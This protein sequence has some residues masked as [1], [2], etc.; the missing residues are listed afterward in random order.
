MAKKSATQIRKE[1]KTPI[2][3]KVLA[4]IRKEFDEDAARIKDDEIM[5]PYLDTEGNEIYFTV[6]IAIPLGEGHGKIPFDGYSEAEN[7][8]MESERK[9]EERKEREKKKAE[10]IAR[11]EARRKAE[12]EMREKRRKEKEGE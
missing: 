1:T 12:A 5:C 10:K 7:Y 11:D 3:E 8:K 2:T 4:F 6:K 9:E